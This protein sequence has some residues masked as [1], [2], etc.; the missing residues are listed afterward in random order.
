MVAATSLP[1]EQ[2]SSSPLILGFDARDAAT[3]AR[4]WPTVTNAEVIG[5]NQA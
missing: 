3:V 2:V 1:P 5:V 4:V